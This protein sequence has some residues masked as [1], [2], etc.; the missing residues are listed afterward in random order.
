[1]KGFI[2]TREVKDGTKP[3]GTPRY[4]KRYDACWRVDGK[5]KQKTFARRK[6]AERFLTDV[7]K[8]VQDG[9]YVEI[10]PTTFK[11]FAERWLEGL[12]DLKPSTRDAY[13]SM[14]TRRLIPAFG[15]RALT[16]LGVEDVNAW[17]Q[18][19]DGTL[20]TKTLRNHLG[21][22]HKL[23]E[24]AREQGYLG[25]NRLSRSRALRRPRPL[26]EDDE[27]EIEVLTPAEANQ[28]LDALAPADLP[29]FFTAVCTGMRLGELL[30]L[31]WGDVDEAGR[32]IHVRRTAY[33]GALYVP[34]SKRS[35]RSIDAG[36]QLL[37]VLSRWRRERHG[38]APPPPD[39]FVFPSAAGGPLDPDNLRHRVWAPTLAKAKLRHVRIHSLRHTFTSML[40][41]QGEN[42]K[43]ISAQ[44]GHAS[45][46]I[47]L[48]RYGHLFPD[49]KRGAA[50]RLEQ[51]LVAGGF[52]RP[53]GS[54]GVDADRREAIPSSG[55]PAER[56]GTPGNSPNSVEDGAGLTARRD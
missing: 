34:K 29:L 21:L 14:L 54:L 26:R 2:L 48:D 6:R 1:M 33:R 42:P 40:I 53:L 25:V 55:H 30:G 51:Q 27:A 24:D 46:Q 22:L 32:R 7:V 44:L 3:D 39:A 52:S 31:Q 56:A 10:K 19:R 36:D 12:G 17:L 8:K 28:L 45:V 35:R 47:T 50:T 37:A 38:E 9:T 11:A 43:Y 23:F 15:D 4:A 5:Q 13:T 16:G 49:E 20:R 41:A 18:A